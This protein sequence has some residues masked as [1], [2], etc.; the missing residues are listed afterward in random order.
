MSAFEARYHGKCALCGERIVPGDLCRFAEDD[1]GVVH[2]DCDAVVLPDEK[3]AKVCTRCWL[4]SC[5][6]EAV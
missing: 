6:C 1:G 4:T 3:P 5:D 2:V